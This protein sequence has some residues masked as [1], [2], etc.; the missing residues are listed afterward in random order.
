M[1]NL[2]P[3]DLVVILNVPYTLLAGLPDDDQD[4]IKSIIGKPVTFAGISYGQA[5]LEFSD[6]QGDVHTIWVDADKI[7]PA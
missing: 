6:N 5:E 3:G 2:Q 7:R 4:A 1:A